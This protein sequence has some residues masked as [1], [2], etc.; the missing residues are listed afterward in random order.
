[1]RL[2]A[3]DHGRALRA[4]QDVVG[5]ELAAARTGGG[6]AAFGVDATRVARGPGGCLYRVDPPPEA[7]LVE[8]A[9]ALLTIGERAIEGRLGS[10]ADESCLVEVPED[11]GPRVLD[12]RLVVD[13]LGPLRGLGQRLAALEGEQPQPPTFRFDQAELVL[14]TPGGRLADEM[15]QAADAAE[16]WRYDDRAGDVLRSALRQRWAQVNTLPGTDAGALVARLLDRLLA[17]DARVL[18]VAPTGAAVDRTVGVLCERLSRSGRLR[19]GLVQRI[20]PLAPG[21]VRDRWGPFV[22]PATIAADLRAG[23]D[24]RLSD[25]DRAEGRMRWDELDRV[26]GAADRDAAEL[27]SML[28]R[29][30]GARRG[31]RDRGIDPDTLVIRR[32]ELRSQGRSARRDADRIASELAAGDRPVPT[33][34]DVVGAAGD[35]AEQRRRLAAARRELVAARD[36][37]EP[38]LRSRLR[39]AAA[40]TRGAYLRGLPRADVD[41]V[42]LAGP[43]LAPEAYYLAGLSTRSVI[44][45]SDAGPGPMAQPAARPEPHVELPPRRRPGLGRRPGRHPVDPQGPPPG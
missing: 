11:L 13:N 15:A 23:V 8:D 39:L 40:T 6:R 43:A 44:S 14:G 42:V 4:M 10:V 24:A 33:V 37:V 3:P 27:D 28:E 30:V 25:L 20:G 36:D 9:P 34:E 16:E 38:A 26:A 21:A 32:H 29:T 17:L 22:E 7:T 31:R 5:R 41:V 1:V 2:R 19:S 35:P 12:G 18:F 45:V